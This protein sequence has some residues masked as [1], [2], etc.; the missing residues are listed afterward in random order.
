[1]RRPVAGA[2]PAPAA[3]GTLKKGRRL[4]SADFLC[5]PR[6]AIAAVYGARLARATSARTPAPRPSPRCWKARHRRPQA[7]TPAAATCMPTLRGLVRRC[8]HHRPHQCHRRGVT[9]A[10]LPAAARR[11]APGQVVATVKIIPLRGVAELI[12]R[13]API[14]GAGVALGLRRSRKS[15]P[16]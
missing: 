11:C 5:W 1:M 12:A 8:R 10:T 14:G 16:R 2:Q 15:A 9:V 3:D 6:P 7:P 4:T 13:C